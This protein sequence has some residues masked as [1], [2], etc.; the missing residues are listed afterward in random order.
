MT[1]AFSK[2]CV[3][4][5]GELAPRLDFRLFEY[6]IVCCRDF[7]SDRLSIKRHYPDVDW[8]PSDM[9]EPL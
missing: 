3:S 9:T 7:Y 8:H 5:V 1:L 6:G 4:H 2:M